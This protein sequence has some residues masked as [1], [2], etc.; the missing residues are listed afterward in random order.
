MKSSTSVQIL[1]E[2]IYVR[3]HTNDFEK[4]MIA[5]LHLAMGK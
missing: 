1:D 3:L 4:G 5:S 2:A